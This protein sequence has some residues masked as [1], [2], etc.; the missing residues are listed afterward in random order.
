[1]SQHSQVIPNSEIN[2]G[3]SPVLEHS[4]WH[5]TQNLFSCKCCNANVQ[6]FSL[7]P[8]QQTSSVHQSKELLTQISTN[9]LNS[10]R[11]VSRTNHSTGNK[12]CNLRCQPATRATNYS[13]QKLN[14]TQTDKECE[15]WTSCLPTLLS[16]DVKQVATMILGNTCNEDPTTLH[17]MSA[18]IQSFI[19]LGFKAWYYCKR[20]YH[21]ETG[22]N[23]PCHVHQPCYIRGPKCK[24]NCLQ[25]SIS[26]NKGNQ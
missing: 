11:S 9:K 23:C 3:Q 16:Q 19:L 20:W 8:V 5:P 25:C 26:T 14:Q 12:L 10:S 17:Q 24:M 13:W 15:S 2:T 6:R 4:S 22:Q 21:K 18:S 7:F 1:M